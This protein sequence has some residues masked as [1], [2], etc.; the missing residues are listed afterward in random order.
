MYCEEYWIQWIHTNIRFFSYLNSYILN[1]ACSCPRTLILFRFVSHLNPRPTPSFMQQNI[2]HTMRSYSV[3]AVLFC[4]LSVALY[5]NQQMEFSMVFFLV[6]IL[7][8]FI[9]F[10]VD[11]F[12]CIQHHALCNSISTFINGL[13][14]V[15][16]I[17]SFF[18]FSD[19]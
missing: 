11:V 15:F 10:F 6:F 17:C 8:A 12:F 2:P 1:G 4:L 3:F 7:I 18:I 9:F 5:N 14:D 13:V 19:I 16:T